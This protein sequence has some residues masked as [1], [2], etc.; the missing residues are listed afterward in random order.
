MNMMKMF[1]DNFGLKLVS[2]RGL[3]I[4]AESLITSIKATQSNLND[5]A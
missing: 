3:C 2:S 1:H 4:A 5:G